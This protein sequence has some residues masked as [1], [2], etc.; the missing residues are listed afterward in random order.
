M[1]TSV[2]CPMSRELVG[3]ALHALE[4]A[5]EIAVRL[6][7]RTCEECRTALVGHDSALAHLG[8]SVDA[9]DPPPDLRRRILRAAAVQLALPQDAAPARREPPA[10]EEPPVRRRHPARRHTTRGRPVRRRLAAAV[11]AAVCLVGAAG[12]VGEVVGDPGS[13]LDRAVAGLAVPGSVHSTLFDTRGDAV[14]AVV[15]DAGTVHVVLAGLPA[16]DRTDSVYVLWGIGSGA[17]QALGT[18]DATG[19]EVHIV[20]LAGSDQHAVGYAVSLEPGRAAPPTP[21]KVVASG[22]LA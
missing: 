10:H 7:L 17:P 4:P 18:F 21:S 6:H 9:V 12:V 16:N 15:A 13:G 1:R 3:Y 2:P 14:A 11:L 8:A 5:E 19:D 20:S 22:Q